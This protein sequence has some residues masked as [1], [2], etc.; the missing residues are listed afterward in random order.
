MTPEGRAYR[1]DVQSMS[2]P[3]VLGSLGVW[4][5]HAPMLSALGRGVVKATAESSE[6]YFAIE[7]G[8]L[9]VRRDEVVVLAPSARAVQESTAAKPVHQA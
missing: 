2:A 5:G 4:P 7:S 3:G 8:F 9:E 1:G 6:Q